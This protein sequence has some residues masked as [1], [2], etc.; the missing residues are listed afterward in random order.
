MAAAVESAPYTG[1]SPREMIESHTLAQE[2]IN[3]NND[4]CP[5][6]DSDEL[7]LL[8]DFVKD[9]SQARAILETR[10]LADD[11]TKS[12]S[13]VAYVISLHGTDKAALTDEEIQILK[14]WFEN[15]QKL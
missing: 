3:R 5:I 1:P 13:L 10:G 7:S 4:A 8:F 14:R 11:P 15:G 6:L 9:P 2:I 12:G